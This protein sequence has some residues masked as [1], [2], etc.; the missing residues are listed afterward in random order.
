MT[1]AHASAFDR[2]VDALAA[3][4]GF[5]PRGR[6]NQREARCPAHDDRNPSL[7]VTRVNDRVLI[8]CHNGC[9]TADI[10]AAIGLTIRDLFDRP[11]NPN[12]NG[13]KHQITDHKSKRVAEYR[14]TDET[15]RVLY[16]IVRKEPG[17]N[18]GDKKTFVTEYPNG[19]TKQRVVYRLTDVMA[20]AMDGRPI[21]LVEGEKDADRL[22]AL[23]VVATT[24]VHGANGW[25]PEYAEP[26]AGATVIIVADR[27]PEGC[28]YAARA[29]ADLRNA[30]CTVRIVQSA[31]DQ[32]HA[33]VSDHL[34]AGLGLD[35]LVPLL[36]APLTTEP[37]TIAATLPAEQEQEADE[38]PPSW[39]P[40]D[41]SDILAGT[42]TPETPAL[43]ARTDGQQLL[44]R[45]R[46][47]SFHGESESGKSLVVQSCA[48]TILN[49]GGW[50]L[51]IDYESDAPAVVG[52][53]LEL[54]VPADVIGQRFRYVQPEASPFSRDAETQ[55]WAELLAGKF[56]LGVIDGVTDALGTNGVKTNDND[57]IAA[58]CR[59]I[60]RP[61][62]RKTGA[63]V[64]LI[65]H[66]TKDADT[67]GRFALGG[68]AK[69]NA[70]DGAAYVVEV[71]EPL[72]RG[73]CGSVKLR[74]AKDRPGGVRGRCGA[75][76]KVDRTQEAARVV[77]DSRD[78]SAIRVA[79]E[80]P[81][82]VA[83]EGGVP[84]RFRPTFLME[85]VSR[86]LLSVGQ[87][88]MNQLRKNVQGKD[89]AIEEA[90]GVLADEGYVAESAGPR[91]ARILSHVRSYTQFGDPMVP[92]TVDDDPQATSARPRP[93]LGPA[94]VQRLR[95]THPFPVGV[96]RGQP[97]SPED[98][99]LA[100]SARPRST[101][102]TAT[103]EPCAEC[104]FPLNSYGH[105]ANCE[106]A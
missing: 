20:A 10:L 60:A 100:T 8:N 90:V 57:E 93:D 18:P 34:D 39:A 67:R 85:R 82:S 91:K 36:E 56:D 103:D 62:A 86:Y 46:V 42:Y 29:A 66:V 11:V 41:L 97:N 55:A 59:R 70:L 101:T 65:D 28:G 30:G 38:P 87:A 78:P 19:P 84:A 44:Y 21:Y 26:F 74:V 43:M 31:I 102:P 1:T 37:G 27:D 94:E 61:I 9:A 40:I 96:G 32:P 77:I 4:T 52:R 54:G 5:R 95:P 63:A 80:P 13:A 22:A 88:S 50:V 25:R 75:F 105:S 6:D 106:A 69:M 48:A 14:Y 2:V 35:D 47:H 7:S 81:A 76:R 23:G 24:S 58:W 53:L 45:G 12:G 17:R 92:H 99:Q 3:T 33:D 16:V 71:D 98:Q 15:G 79:I 72:G 73:L 89:S 104:G 51:Y 64:V 68:Q 83:G 49:G